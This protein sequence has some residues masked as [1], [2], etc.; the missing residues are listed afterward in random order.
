MVGEILLTNEPTEKRRKLLPLVL[1]FSALL[2]GPVVLGLEV[3]DTP[4]DSVESRSAMTAAPVPI[5][6]PQQLLEGR[7]LV[8]ICSAKSVRGK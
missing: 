3:G 8:Q 7:D 6:L 4:K 2:L 1:V 5:Y